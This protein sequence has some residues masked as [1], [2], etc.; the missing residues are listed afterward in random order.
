MKIGIFETLAGFGGGNVYLGNVQKVL[1]DYHTVSIFRVQGNGL[2]GKRFGKILHAAQVFRR[3][4]EIDLWICTYLPTIAQVISKPRA[5]VV[6]LFYHLD[7]VF[8]PNPYLS[9]LLSQLYFLLARRCDGV[10]TIAQYWSEFLAAKGVRVTDIIYWGFTPSGFVFSQQEIN[11][12]KKKY[13]LFG[14]PVVY[15]GNCLEQKG[16][17]DAYHQLKNLDAHL[18]TSG[19]RRVDLPVPNLELNYE[20][21]RLLLAS[22]DLVLTLSKFKE[23]WNGTAHEAMLAGT[24]VIGSGLGGMSELLKGGGQVICDDLNQLEGYVLNVI[25]HREE[26]ASRGKIFAAQFTWERFMKA[27]QDLVARFEY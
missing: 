20:E 13:G 6:S 5:K 27:W 24:P 3:H 14:K 7:D 17:V 21:Y 10:V 2:L 12:F 26:Y 1:S 18:V 15:L 8:Y 25:E 16:V 22:S 19:V 23:G 11:D 9:R 4:P